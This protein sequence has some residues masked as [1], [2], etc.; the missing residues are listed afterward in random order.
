MQHL[1]FLS[2]MNNTSIVIVG[3]GVAGTSSAVALWRA[4][5]RDIVLLERGELG[6][7]ERA[8][9]GAYEHAQRSGSAVMDVGVAQR[10]K[11]IVNLYA[12]S[13]ALFASHH[14]ADGARR[15]LRSARRGIAIQLAL[16]KE[17][18]ADVIQLGS[19]YVAQNDA[20]VVA[21][22][23]EFLALQSAGAD[24]IALWSAEQVRA[25]T[26]AE[27]P[28]AIFFPH[29]A[30][31]D[32][33]QYARLLMQKA[34]PG[35][36]V[37]EHCSPVVDVQDD[38][39]NHTVTTLADGT[40][41]RSNQALV[42]TGGLFLPRALTG[43]LTPCYSYLVALPQLEPAQLHENTPNIFTWGFTHDLCMTRGWMRVSGADHF[44]AL[45]PPRDAERCAELAA[46]T[47]EW[48][49]GKLTAQGS[50]NQ[51]GVYSETP[52]RAPLLGP[53]RAGS[54]VHYLLGCQAWGQ[55]ILSSLASSIPAVMGIANWQSKEEQDEFEN[56]FTAMRFSVNRT[57]C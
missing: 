6:N 45:K 52:D 23:S 41:Y 1:F 27:F 44:S 26:G 31:I 36:R 21:L 13:T 42:A 3:G 56:L 10:I 57:E 34:A 49:R 43:L 19:L 5:V 47:C 46:W 24:G 29:D 51:Y 38:G 35:V 32:S 40:T 11:M 55:A 33:A 16:A 7:G 25:A 53:L 37:V 17:I 2:F 4:G 50:L 20:D 8:A 12:A 18:G 48:F 9:L 28:R 14:G 22:E 15:Y 54:R 30:V 39:A